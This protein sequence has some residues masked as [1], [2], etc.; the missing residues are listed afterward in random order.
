MAREDSPSKDRPSQPNKDEDSGNKNLV[1]WNGKCP[2]CGLELPTM[3][4]PIP[5][6]YDEDGKTVGIARVWINS[7]C[8]GAVT[9]LKTEEVWF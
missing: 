8:C 9:H 3:Y 5:W 1:P 2:Q 6:L 7:E 4:A